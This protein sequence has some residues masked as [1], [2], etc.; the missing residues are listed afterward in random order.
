MHEKINKSQYPNEGPED[1][2]KVILHNEEKAPRRV[3]GMKRVKK[4]DWK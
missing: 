1:P 4:M 2:V 3:L